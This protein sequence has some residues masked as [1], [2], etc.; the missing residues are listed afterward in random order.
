MLIWPAL[1]ARCSS[2]CL[3]HVDSFSNNSVR[4][5]AILTLTS[6]KRKLK[7]RE[8]KPLVKVTQLI[9]SWAR[10]IGSRNY[11]VW[12][13][14]YFLSNKSLVWPLLNI[15]YSHFCYNS[16]I[17]SSFSSYWLCPNYFSLFLCDSLLHTFPLLCLT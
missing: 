1:C 6:G 7:H 15:S 12:L 10:Q 3:T 11:A 2:K 14:I 5:C 9:S 8:A 16:R 17:Y 4:R 13:R